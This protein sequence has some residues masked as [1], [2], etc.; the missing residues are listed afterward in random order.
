[1]ARV[2]TFERCRDSRPI[3]E[4]LKRVYVGPVDPRFMV[5][6]WHQMLRQLDVSTPPTTTHYQYLVAFTPVGKLGR[7]P[8]LTSA[9]TWL[10]EELRWWREE[11]DPSQS[12]GED[13]VATAIGF[14]LFPLE[15]LSTQA[16]EA[17]MRSQ[18]MDLTGHWPELALM[19]VT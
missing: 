3:A 15:A 5:S 19:D 16:E 6:L 2:P 7:V 4:D 8:D 1:M 17:S 11:G 18:M 14:W 12:I 9:K 10:R 13:M